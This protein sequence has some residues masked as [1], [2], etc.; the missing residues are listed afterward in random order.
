MIESRDGDIFEQKDL[1]HIVHQAN[2]Y[3]TFGSGIARQIRERFPYACDADLATPRSDLSKLGGFS[4]GFDPLGKGPTI[5]N[6]YSQV[7]IGGQ[8]RRT[9]YDAMVRGLEQLEASLRFDGPTGSRRRQPTVLGIPYG[10][11]CGLANGDWRIVQTIIKCVFGDDSDV[12]T[13]ICCLPG[14]TLP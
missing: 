1:T 5:V 7:G 13:V 10:I 14:R 8:D 11:G 6:L 2:L 4:L 9:S 3:H 12:Q